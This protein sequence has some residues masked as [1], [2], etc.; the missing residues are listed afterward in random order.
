MIVTGEGFP[1]L[2]SI[3]TTAHIVPAAGQRLVRMALPRPEGYSE[4]RVLW[5]PE[6]IDRVLSGDAQILGFA[7]PKFMSCRQRYIGGM[8]VSGS[9]NGDPGNKHPD[10]ERLTGCNEVWVMCFRAPPDNQWRLMGRFV[11]PNEFVGLALFSRKFLNG[12]RH[13]HAQ[14]QNLESGWPPSQ[15]YFVGS[16]IEDYISQPVRDLYVPRL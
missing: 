7:D 16:V 2:T 10:F 15:P 5:V 8:L 9:M 4:K 13:Y 12:K 1:G 11:R 3:P 6:D 14:A